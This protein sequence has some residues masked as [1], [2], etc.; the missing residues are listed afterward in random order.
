MAPLKRSKAYQSV[1]DSQPV[2]RYLNQGESEGRR[3]S[4]GVTQAH[5]T[6]PAR[7]GMLYESRDGKLCLFESSEGHLAAVKASRLA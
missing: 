6:A 5:T 2:I 1:S 3:D 7:F 4:S